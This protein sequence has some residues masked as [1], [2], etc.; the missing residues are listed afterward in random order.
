MY[1]MMQFIGAGQNW[2]WHRNGLNETGDC[3][4]EFESFDCHWRRSFSHLSSSVSSCQREMEFSGNESP[5]IADLEHASLRPQNPE[6]PKYHGSN[7][8]RE[9]TKTST[10][11]P[12]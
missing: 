5:A 8:C 3:L 10:A 6:K 11:S 9:G 4:H 12:S 1:Q 7:S 2:P